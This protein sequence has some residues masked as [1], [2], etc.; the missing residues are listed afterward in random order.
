VLADCPICAKPLAPGQVTCA[1]CGFP[2]ALAPDARHIM[3]EPETQVPL[4]ETGSRG[5]S[6]RRA[7]SAK[8][9]GGRDAQADLCYRLAGE[10]RTGLGLVRELGAD[11][12]EI[13]SEMRQ[14]ALTQAD[15]RVSEALNVLRGALARVQNKTKELCNQRIEE[16]VLRQA[17][18]TQDGVGADF[19]TEIETIREKFATNDRT[20]AVEALRVTESRVSRVESDWRGL[21]GLLGQIEQLRAAAKVSGRTVAEV[22]ADVAHVRELLSRSPVGIESLDS[23]AQQAAR[24]LMLLHEALPPLLEAELAEHARVLGAF[25][26]DHPP[27]RR[28]RGLHGEAARH[29]RRGRLAEATVSLH[30]LREVLKTLGRPEPPPVVRV[31]VA[32]VGP[33]ID[34]EPRSGS[35][36]VPVEVAVPPTPAPPPPTLGRLLSRARELAARV[37]SLPHDSEVAFEAAAE[38]RRATELLRARKL[39]EAERTLTRLMMT[40]SVEP[41]PES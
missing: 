26:T 24:A 12:T 36:P 21:K 17:A 38:I 22:E 34:F 40:L 7:G 4:L 11:A 19:S 15:G 18:L 3:E 8:P 10:I 30:E 35:V 20:G 28:A 37:R 6:S 29:L 27:S 16:L 33:S 14:A 32:T 23:A 1:V 2:V 13:V 9:V 39:E 31:P 5:T 41:V 25:P